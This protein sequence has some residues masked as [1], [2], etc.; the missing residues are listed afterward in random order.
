MSAQP[1]KRRPHRKSIQPAD[2]AIKAWRDWPPENQRFYENF[3]NWLKKGGFSDS[4][5]NIYGVAARQA[6]GFLDKYYWQIDPDGDLARAWGRLQSHP[7]SPSTQ[8]GYRKG[9]V[10][11][12]EYLRLVCDRP[13]APKPVLWDH[14]LGM[15]PDWLACDV[16]DFIAHRARAWATDR[17]SERTCDLLSHL[18]RPLRWMAAHFELGEIGDLTPVLWEAYLDMRLADGIQPR[19]TNSELLELQHWLRFLQ[20]QGR[21]VC[22]RMLRVER[23]FEGKSLPKDVPVD[24][25]RTLQE[26]IRAEAVSDERGRSRTGKMDLVWFLLMLHSGLRT[27]EVR[28]LRFADLNI[29]ARQARI[30]QSKGL[31]DRMVYLSAVTITALQAYLAVR[32]PRDALPEHIFIYRHQPLG[33]F[34]CGQRL[35][36]YGER[37]GVYTSPHRLRHSCATLLLNAGAPVLTVQTLLG[38]KWVDT[39]LGYARLYDGTVAADYYGAMAMV[40]RRMALPEDALAEPPGTGQLLALIDS[41]REGTLNQAQTETVRRLRT[42]ILAL[43]ERENAI[44]DVK[45]L[46]HQP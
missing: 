15:L 21:P 9:L 28:D 36:T 35:Q 14:F 24:Q 18:T 4:T 25:L 12:A 42:G 13:Q 30:E 5:L 8:D 37:C 2:P 6:L 23:L 17:K 32:G 46:T 33:K 10:K 34:Y 27:C 38:H 16:R 43:A 3:H 41:L 39:T 22:A 11:L 7:T 1:R 40:E 26:A 29:A 20:D 31:K 44:Q 45:V 19:T